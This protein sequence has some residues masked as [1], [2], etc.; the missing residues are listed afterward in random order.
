MSEMVERVA[1]AIAPI[2]ANWDGS[3]SSEDVARRAIEGDYALLDYAVGRSYR[4]LRQAALLILIFMVCLLGI[5]EGHEFKPIQVSSCYSIEGCA[6]GHSIA[7]R[8]PDSPNYKETPF[9]PLAA[10]GVTPRRIKIRNLPRRGL[11]LSL[12]ECR[13]EEEL[14]SPNDVS[15]LVAVPPSSIA[16]N[17]PNSN[18]VVD[19][20][21]WGSSN[22]DD[23]VSNGNGLIQ[24]RLID[25]DQPDAQFWTMGGGEFASEMPKLPVGGDEQSKGEG[26]NYECGRRVENFSMGVHDIAQ[27][28]GGP[29]DDANPGGGVLLALIILGG[30]GG[31]CWVAFR[32]A[33][34]C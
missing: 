31:L 30:W 6:A 24:D 1:N 8:I 9:P 21:G 16:W 7:I 3:Y 34:G 26:T 15:R 27:D 2:L 17:D 18:F 33:L 12:S 19:N 11:C 29:R 22:I 32:R 20:V 23:L 5:A 28:T 25:L 14:L 13:G 4:W 10:P